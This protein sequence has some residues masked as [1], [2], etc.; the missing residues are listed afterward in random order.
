MQVSLLA[1]AGLSLC[2]KTLAV[3]AQKQ[4]N[5]AYELSDPVLTVQLYPPS[6]TEFYWQIFTNSLVL[7]SGWAEQ[8]FAQLVLFGHLRQRFVAGNAKSLE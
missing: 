7:G 8:S 1:L 4:Q 2:V 6:N 5:K 3:F